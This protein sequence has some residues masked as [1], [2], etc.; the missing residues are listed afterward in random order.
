MIEAAINGNVDALFRLASAF[1]FEVAAVIYQ[2]LTALHA[3]TPPAR[4]PQRVNARA[5]NRLNDSRASH[6]CPD[7]STRDYAYCQ[8][9]T[10]AERAAGAGHQPPGPERGRLARIRGK[11]QI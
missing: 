1:H 11:R 6:S 2:E 5:D 10:A 4:D 9:D 3:A 7:G 8:V